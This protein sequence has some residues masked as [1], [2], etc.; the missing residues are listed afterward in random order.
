MLASGPEEEQGE[1]R[2]KGIRHSG[3]GTT[4]SCGRSDSGGDMT[5]CKCVLRS[6]FIIMMLFLNEKCNRFGYCNLS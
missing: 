4:S 6:T 2:R 3:R 5:T 1:E